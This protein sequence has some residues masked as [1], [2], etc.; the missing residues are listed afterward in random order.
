MNAQE[1]RNDWLVVAAVG[2]I[3]LGVWFLLGNLL[4]TGWQQMVRAIFRIA[5]PIALIALGV[6]LFISSSRGGGSR[7]TGQRLYRS[8]DD[9]KVGGVL[10]GVA[11][12]F[13][14]D[15][16]LVRVLY[17]V[18]ALLSGVWLALVAYVIA[19]V[20][21]PEQP[22]GERGWDDAKRPPQPPTAP[23]GTGWPHTGAGSAPPPAPPA[24]QSPQAPQAPPPPPGGSGDAQ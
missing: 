5:W 17:V 20:V 14:A 21:V 1:Q 6:L 15:P 24:P 23:A 9:R 11:E 2:L 18:F 13:G 22:D 4:G 10:A 16:T 3:A 19:M 8:R 12:Y 7:T